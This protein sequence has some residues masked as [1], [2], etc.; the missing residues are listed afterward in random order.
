M[1]RALPGDWNVEVSFAVHGE[2]AIEQISQGKGDIMF[3]DLNMPVMNGYET[4]EA[5]IKNDLPSKVVVVSGDIQPEALERVKALGALGF[6]K[7]PIGEAELS[8][9]LQDLGLYAPAADEDRGKSENTAN[10]T[11]I[12][13]NRSRPD[14]AGAGQIQ[15]LDIIQEVANVAMGQAAD[16]LARLLNVFIKLPVPNVNIL[17]VCELKMVLSQVAQGETYAAVCQGF[18][19]SGI[20]GE[21]LLI[22]SDSSY[23]DMAKLL[24]YNGELNDTARLELIT[25]I[26][27]ILVGACIGGIA[28]QL[29]ISISQGHTMV[30]GRHVKVSELIEANQNRWKETLA[31]E[32]T[33]EIESYRVTCDMLLLFTEDSIDNL[34]QRL[35]YLME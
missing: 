20:A 1:A 24:K 26:A 8:V 2:D 30:I 9:T 14:F 5:I 17:E 25:D 12:Q 28:Q 15:Y 35:A 19:G 21:A 22:F 6:I 18:I 27:S 31:I 29:D 10:S 34:N 32:I 3:L 11:G 4:L 7:K 16:L 23:E 13:L 33:Y